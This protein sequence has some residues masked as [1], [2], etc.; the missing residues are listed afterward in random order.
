VPGSGFRVFSCSGQVVTVH[1]S[2]VVREIVKLK[3]WGIVLNQ[4]LVIFKKGSNYKKLNPRIFFPGHP[5][6]C[7]F[8]LTQKYQKV[9]AEE[10]IAK[11]T[12]IPLKSIKLVLLRRTSNNIDFLTLH[13]CFFFTHFFLCLYKVHRLPP[14]APRN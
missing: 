13:F 11:K 3:N 8:V 1:W 9:K 14:C 6:V 7:T 4:F 12:F 10:K 2:L 5:F